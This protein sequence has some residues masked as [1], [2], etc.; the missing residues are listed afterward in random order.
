MIDQIARRMP[1]GT[2]DRLVALDSA[3]LAL[4]NI[5]FSSTNYA[6]HYQHSI[7]F[8][9]SNVATLPTAATADTL[10]KVNI[11]QW[12]DPASHIKVRDP[13]WLLN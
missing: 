1:T 3:T 7:A 8:V 10:V 11:G 4:G 13:K 6:A 5:D 2:V 9:A 12:S